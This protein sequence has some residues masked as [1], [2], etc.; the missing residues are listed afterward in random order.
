MERKR[1]V[2]NLSSEH[3][4]ALLRARDEYQQR[5][6][7]EITLDSFVALLLYE[8]GGCIDQALAKSIRISMAVQ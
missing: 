6:H 3:H 7:C 4:V 2:V 1:T 5:Q 8:Y